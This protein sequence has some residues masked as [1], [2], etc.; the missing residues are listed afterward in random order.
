[1]IWAETDPYNCSIIEDE[2]SYGEVG[3][4]KPAIQIRVSGS[5]VSGN[6]RV[7]HYIIAILNA[8]KGFEEHVKTL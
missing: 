8:L 6:E 5:P 3:S 4:C 1:M 7:I 2:G